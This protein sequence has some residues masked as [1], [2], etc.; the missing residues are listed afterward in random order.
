M[1]R[2]R[3]YKRIVVLIREKLFNEFFP[4]STRVL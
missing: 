1:V 3:H 2:R 4:K